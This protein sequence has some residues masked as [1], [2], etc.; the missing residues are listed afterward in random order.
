MSRCKEGG[1]WPEEEGDHIF[2]TSG[3]S[4]APGH[5]LGA[6]KKC[7]PSVVRDE[8]HG[9]EVRGPRGV[10]SSDVM[11][12]RNKD[13][14]YSI[15]SNCLSEFAQSCLTLCDPMDCSLQ[16]SSIHLIA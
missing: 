2:Q 10:S 9:D 7:R 15:F 12:E 4:S 5:E 11:R 8:I 1:L 6:E 16:G 3:S 13:V 14:H